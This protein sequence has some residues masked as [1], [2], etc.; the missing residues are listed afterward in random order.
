MHTS[1]SMLITYAVDFAL[2]DRLRR[3]LLDEGVVDDGHEDVDVRVGRDGDVC[4]DTTQDGIV[5]LAKTLERIC[6]RLAPSL[7]D[8]LVVD[9]LPRCK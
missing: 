2:S 1:A 3:C 6:L 8:D 9:G 5:S 4:V 7:L